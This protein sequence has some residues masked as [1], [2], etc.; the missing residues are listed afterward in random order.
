MIRGNGNGKAKRI[1]PTLNLGW[2][3]EKARSLAIDKNQIAT[4]E[5][6]YQTKW[7]VVLRD[8]DPVSNRQRSI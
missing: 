3:V 7:L 4:T 1:S 5:H 2:R 6:N 8:T